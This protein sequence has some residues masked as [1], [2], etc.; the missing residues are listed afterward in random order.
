MKVLF[1]DVDG[2]LNSRSTSNFDELYPLDQYK[3][4]LI[5]RIQLQTG[6]EVV[7][8][9][10]WRNHPEGV[11]N[12]S[13]RVVRLLDKTPSFHRDCEPFM[14]RGR[15]W[16]H[17]IRGDEVNA[18]LKQHPEVTNYAILDDDGDFYDEQPLFQ[19]TFEEGLTDDIAETVIEHLNS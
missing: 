11:E 18:W 16:E 3:A 9:S 8:S 1:L 12:V 19:T 13:K 10:S 15:E 6:C 14:A 17:T 2:V 7:L 5:G 4:F